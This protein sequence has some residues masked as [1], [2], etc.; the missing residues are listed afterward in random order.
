MGE[1]CIGP[2][3]RHG[4]KGSS[5]L[6]VYSIFGYYGRGEWLNQAVFSRKLPQGRFAP[7]RARPLSLRTKNFEGGG[8]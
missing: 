8:I 7:V 5:F 2:W 6:E 1:G 4:L 3:Y